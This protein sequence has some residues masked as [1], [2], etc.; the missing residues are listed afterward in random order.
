MSEQVDETE[1]WFGPDV[2][3]L[4]C[5]VLISGEGNEY[6][7]RF[8]LPG[9]QRRYHHILASDPDRDMHDHPWDFTSKLIRGVYIE[10]TP[11]GSIRYEAPC[12]IHRKAEQ[13]HSLELPEG[14]V[15][16]FVMMGPVRRKWGFKTPGGWVPWDRYNGGSIAGCGP[17]NPVRPSYTRRRINRRP[18]W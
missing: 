3:G 13:L 9:S 1:I 6:M 18:K 15:W 17:E 16:S 8:Y 4:P 10:H 2:S 12:V 11:R 7:R 14:P 5:D